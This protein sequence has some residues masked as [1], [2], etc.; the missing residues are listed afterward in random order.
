MAASVLGLSALAM[1]GNVQNSQ[2]FRKVTNIRPVVESTLLVSPQIRETYST[3][4]ISPSNPKRMVLPETPEAN[5]LP[6]GA[7]TL[8][9]R[10]SS[11]DPR[12]PAIDSTGYF[13]P[14]PDIAVGPTH[15]VAVVNTTIAFYTKTG[16]RTFQSEMGNDFGGQGFFESLGITDFVFD[17]KAFYDPLSG[18]FFVV[19]LEVDDANQVSKALIAVSDDSDP[20]G[21]WFKYRVDSKLTVGSNNFWM[22]YPGF[23]CNKDAVAISGNMFGFSSGGAGV[24][25]IV[26]PKA[27]MLTGGAATANYL[28]D[29]NSFTAQIAETTDA[30]LDR[31][32]SIS[33]NNSSSMTVHAITGLPSSPALS[34]RD[35][36]VP[37]FLFVN[38]SPASTNGHRLD[39]FDGRLFNA[40]YRNGKIYT[41][42]SVRVSS[43]DNRTQ[44]R[45][46]EIATNNFPTSG[47]NP[48]T[49]QS[50]N[51]AFATPGNAHMPAINV[52]SAGDVSI[53]F[54]RSSTA[55]V[56][57]I[58]ITG[59]A[60]SDPPGTMGTPTL[61]KSS[62]GSQYGGNGTNRWGDYFGCD[63]DPS[64][65]V[66]FWGIGMIGKANGNWITEIQ[67]WKISDIPTGNSAI[68]LS[69]AS[70]TRFPNTLISGDP[71]LV[72]NQDGNV[73]TVPSELVANVGQQAGAQAKYVLDRP[74]AQV[75][76]F[77]VRIKA[78]GPAAATVMLWVL[79]VTTNKYVH[80]KSFPLTETGGTVQTA[81]I[82]TGLSKY[83]NPATNEI[84]IAT[85][86]S[87]PVRTNRGNPIIP[88][89]F[90]FLIDLLE[91]KGTGS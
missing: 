16:T 63:V 41:A 81:T 44:V 7:A 9:N 12:F 20:N 45:W 86:A 11:Y 17:P 10:I 91:I 27:P 73:F 36:A 61:L 72:K 19:L 65:N 38:Q 59:R 18:R 68:N 37:S 69:A 82:S 22:D 52:N 60:A 23:G 67:S 29:G 39:G 1:A 90:D 53:I 89:P 8:P 62:L 47:N 87:I 51:V 40:A 15:V 21:T 46:Y 26:L 71:N 76:S 34:S 74:V 31:I 43:T 56:A 83:V 54:T 42:H 49:S 55:I 25:W 79:D 48:A 6:V 64:D 30:T 70:L 78:N 24:M 2:P 3:K 13:P 50:G 58:M 35:T 88:A 77:T 85:R 84:T 5:T 28:R 4:T 33:T 80:L 75:R 57:D 14:D 66:T 32:Y